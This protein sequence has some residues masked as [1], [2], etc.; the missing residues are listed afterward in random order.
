MNLF[1]NPPQILAACA[2]M[3]LWL[4]ASSAYASLVTQLDFTG[5]S[6]AF[7]L[8][9]TTVLSEN[10]TQNGTIVMGQYQPLPNIIPPV[11]VAGYTFQ[12]FTSGPNPVPTGNTNGSTIT[13]DL[14]SLS[15]GLTGPG[16]GSGVSVNIGGEATGVFNPSTNAFANLS[17]ID[18]NPIPGKG[19]TSLVF[20]LN[21]TA[22]VAVVPLPAAFGLFLTGLSGIVAA[23][24]RRFA[25]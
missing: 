13:S 21:G 23:R 20:T 19:W 11:T 24:M 17:W 10:F 7:K 18:S 16:L 4:A 14:T 3:A 25:A 12:L 6:V 5:G 22:Q 8:G 2:G 1:R 15:A 9:S